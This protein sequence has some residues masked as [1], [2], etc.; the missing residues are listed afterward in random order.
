M[1][2]LL[3]TLLWPSGAHALQVERE[4]KGP[5]V[6][7]SAELPHSIEAVNSILRQDVKTMKLGQ[8][9]RN[10]TATPLSNGCTQLKVV[11][12]GF[13][14]DLSYIAERCPTKNGWHSKMISSDDFE[15]HEII[16]NTDPSGENSKVT[17]RVK[18]A[19][20]YPVPQFLVN[21]IVGGALEETLEKIDKALKAE[22]RTQ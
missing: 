12:E 3:L 17:I 11:N 22:N 19:L 21:R 10:V 15:D 2:V 18:V 8:A 5:Y 6:V 13:A 14:K 16:W 9:V 4:R 20:K 7:V 1:N